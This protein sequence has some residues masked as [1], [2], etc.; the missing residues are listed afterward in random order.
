MSANPTQT[1]KVRVA[2]AGIGNCS[3]SLVQ[4]VTYYR[5]ASP[6]DDVPGL[7]HQLADLV[8]EPA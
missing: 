5:D 3:S 8:S 4:G 1:K 2:I 7:M 6:D